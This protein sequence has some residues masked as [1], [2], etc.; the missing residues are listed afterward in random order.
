MRGIAI[1]K[2]SYP[3]YKVLQSSFRTH[4]EG[5]SVI[6]ATLI[7]IVVA[8][9][10]ALTVAYIMGAFSTNISRQIILPGSPTASP[11]PLPGTP[12]IIIGD[13]ELTYPIDQQLSSQYMSS[14]NGIVIENQYSDEDT[15]IV[16][17][18][19]NLIDIVALSHAPSQSML[20]MYPDLKSYLIGGRAIVVIANPNLNISSLSRSDLSMVYNQTQQSL[21]L[22]LTGLKMIIR[23]ND[24]KGS[25]A[26][27]AQWLTDGAASSLDGYMAAPAGVSNYTANSEAD[28]ISKVSS[29]P[30]AIGFVDW[31]Y[32]AT[33]TR[34]KVI[35]I[36]N[37]N[38]LSVQTPTAQSIIDEIVQ[39]NNANYD[40]GLIGQL[41]YV[42][43]GSPSSTESDYINWTQSSE[44]SSELN[45]MYIYGAEDLGVS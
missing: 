25:E 41:Y 12:N 36:V 39:M 24:G 32:V 15:N 38:T 23:N 6:I 43:K 18:G 35:P 13:E 9:M 37:T 42:T 4:D 20:F 16:A 1:S 44:G 10:G 22:S 45:N 2:A 19:K 31:N 14:Y 33:N 7:L 17:L 8:I 34:V 3:T 40:D 11:S 28:V 26:I 21:P 30:G 27:F 29:T 5:V